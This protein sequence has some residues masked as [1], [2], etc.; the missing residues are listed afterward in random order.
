VGADNPSMRLRRRSASIAAACAAAL[1]LVGCHGSHHSAERPGL[2]YKLSTVPL[3]KTLPARA[4]FVGV[5]RYDVTLFAFSP[6]PSRLCDRLADRYFRGEK[7]L[8]WSPGRFQNSDTVN[9]C[10]LS[11]HGVRLAVSRGDPDY[12]G[13]RFDRAEEASTRV[14]AALRARGWRKTPGG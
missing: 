4:C 9:E 2:V 11:R 13:P 10:D 5:L 14:C 6:R 3:P 8:P 1:F 7:H 12:E